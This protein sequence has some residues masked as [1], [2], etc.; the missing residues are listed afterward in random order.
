MSAVKWG[1]IS[2]AKINGLFLEGA[3][4]ADG[5]EIA[6]V[7]SRD[8]AKAEEYAREN[9]IATAHGSYEELLE[10]PDIEAVYI[11]LPNSFH[12]E[13]S[14]KALRAGKHVLCEKPLSRRAEEVERAFDAAEQHERML[15]EAVMWR[16]HPQTAKLAELF[17]EQSQAEPRRPR[18]L[19]A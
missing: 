15:M 8:K 3:R 2:T 7:A 14:L 18:R 6:A 4:G 10:D 9:D 17:E 12:I 19:D 16:H 11:S 13:W 5:V 1:I